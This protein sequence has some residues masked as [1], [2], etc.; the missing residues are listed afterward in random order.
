M[1]S[2][3]SNLFNCRMRHFSFFFLQRWTF[4]SLVLSWK[5]QLWTKFLFWTFKMWYVFERRVDDIDSKMVGKSFINVFKW[6]PWTFNHFLPFLFL[7][8]SDGVAFASA[9]WK[10]RCASR[11][12]RFTWHKA[13]LCSTWYIMMD[14]T[15]YLLIHIYFVS[16]LSALVCG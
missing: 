1:F 2:F 15:T 5:I 6:I 12:C 8:Q 4:Q 3:K 13:L 7:S 11:F 10:D 16:T 14:Y 9:S